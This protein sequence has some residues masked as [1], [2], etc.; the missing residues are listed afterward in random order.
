M[1]TLIEL[2]PKTPA[3]ARLV[4]C[5]EDLAQRMARAAAEYD[6]TGQY[7]LPH[8]ALLKQ[9]G[10]FGAPIPEQ[11]GGRGVESTFDILVASSRLA[12][13]DASMTLG[14]NMHLQI[15]MSMVRR[16]RRAYHRGDER[17]AGAFG[18]S[19]T[20]IVDD[21]VV[22][23][24]AVSEPNQNLTEPATRAARTDDGWV[25]NGRKIF[26]SMSPAATMLLVSTLYEDSAGDRR[27]GYAE[28]PA[29]A[30]GVTIHDDWDALGMRASGSNSVSFGDVHLPQAALR[31]GFP[32]GNGGGYIE[33]NLAN[34]LF[35][36]SASVGIAEAAHEAAIGRLH[37]R[38]S[39]EPGPAEHGRNRAEPG[40]SAEPGPVEHGC[41]RAEPGPNEHG[42]TSA[43]PGPA[44][45]MLSAENTI[46]LSAMRATFGRAAE[47]VDAFS[48]ARLASDAVPDE[49]CAVFAEVQA[50]KAFVG[51][52]ASRIVDRALT[53]SGGA[54]YR[55]SHVLS[56][57]YRDVR[58]GAFMQPLSSLRAYSYLAQA[59]L[60]L[61]PSLA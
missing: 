39:A 41:N 33:R 57:A 10:Y 54:G 27:Y 49:W 28:V 19:L 5:A 44:E 11:F 18:R 12:R 4:A 43:E 15:L 14:V 30:L 7:P 24:A 61:E 53:L 47:L 34:G 50:A 42:R 35:H 25:L 55:R 8:V 16:W 29:N 3:G 51:E 20:R 56:R 9:A 2:Q 58:A 48:A 6:T 13:G 23:A 59:T 46:A 1:A 37:G 60:G 22:I 31:G 38:N 36:A 32:V 17:R 45:Q 26:C 52:A 40:N 21:D